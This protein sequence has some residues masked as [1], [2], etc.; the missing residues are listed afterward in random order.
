MIARERQLA[1]LTQFGLRCNAEMTSKVLRETCPLDD[2]CEAYLKHIVEERKS[3]SAR[4]IDRLIKVART[5][6]D[7]MGQDAIDKQCL[8]E[9]A[10]YRAIDPTADIFTT[11]PSHPTGLPLIARVR[12]SDAQTATVF[13]SPG[14]PLDGEV[15]VPP[16]PEGLANANRELPPLPAPP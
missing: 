14:C 13:V 8:H 1:R 9:A 16:T 11:L 12:M 7:L 10:S 3:M 4:S 2:A 6:A 5:I 15:V